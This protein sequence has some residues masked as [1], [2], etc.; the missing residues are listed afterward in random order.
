MTYYE[1]IRKLAKSYYWQTLYNSSKD[2]SSVSLFENSS[3]F[4]GLQMLFLYWLQ[5]YSI[6][7]D[8][9]SQ[10]KWKHLDE[11]VIDNNIRCDAFL[12][13]RKKQNEAE[14]DKYKREQ[15]INNLKLKDK[16]NVTTFDVDFKG[17]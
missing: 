4:S 11:S 15:Q 6:L 1:I 16:S 5:V 10:K 9:L 13:W 17:N 7:Y 14:V 8:E 2:I 3:N 12:F